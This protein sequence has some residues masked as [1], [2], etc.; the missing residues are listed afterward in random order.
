LGLDD[1][2]DNANNFN[3]MRGHTPQPW[4][5]GNTTEPFPNEA[6]GIVAMYGGRWPGAIWG[7]NLFA[8][9]QFID[10]YGS[11]QI[12]WDPMETFRVCKNTQFS[13]RVSIGN[14]GSYDATSGFKLY[15]NN[16]GNPADPGRT[17]WAGTATMYAYTSLTQLLT[18]TIP[19]NLASGL[20]W[21][22]WT[23][24][25]NSTV[26]EWNESDNTVHCAMS[27]QVVWC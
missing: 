21:F 4:A 5:G 3:V 16:T 6:A 25:S 19:A 27:V 20:Y 17:G 13:V 23:I 9:A 1:L 24:D 18:F 14:N 10:P 8:S 11:G 12:A 15:M 22:F 2:P 26:T 7:T